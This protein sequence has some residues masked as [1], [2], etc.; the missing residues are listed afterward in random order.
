MKLQNKTAIVT[1]ASSGIGLAI[2]KTFLEEGANVV[3]SDINEETGQQ[4]VS[5]LGEKASFFKCNVANADEVYKLVESTVSKYGKLDIMVNNAG[6]A[7]SGGTLDCTIEGWKKVIDINL[8]GVFYGVSAAAK[9]MKATNT[10][11]SIINMSSILGLV[12]M[13][14]SIAYS[15]A[16]GGVSNLTRAA[17]QDLA[18]L[19]IRVNAIAPG[20][21][22]TN[23]TKGG[24]ADENFNNMVIS[25]TPLGHVG[26]TNDIAKAALYL[27]SEDS[28][29]VTGIVLPVDGGWTCR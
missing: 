24:L 22:E 11:G 9:A 17:A 4:I 1:G 23:M 25:N 28:S 7:G 12:G 6:I 19:K 21:I 5:Q 13:P 10:Q 20:F 16:K 15:A 3:F 26:S 14:G 27:A 18:P 29:Y 8:S 2:A